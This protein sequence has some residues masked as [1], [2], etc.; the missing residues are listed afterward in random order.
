[1]FLF[2]SVMVCYPIGAIKEQRQPKPQTPIKFAPSAPAVHLP[3][4]VK[5]NEKRK[6]LGRV[7][8]D[9]KY[10]GVSERVFCARLCLRL[11]T[12]SRA[13]CSASV[14]AVDAR[15]KLGVKVADDDD[16]PRLRVRPAPASCLAGFA[17]LAAGEATLSRPTNNG[18]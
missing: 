13:C 18:R 2:F 17:E 4:S 1:M 5:R 16:F 15:G 7:H 9:G 6:L 3:V 14:D 8:G 12:L 11:H 10:E